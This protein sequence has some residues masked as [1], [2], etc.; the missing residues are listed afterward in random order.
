MILRQVVQV[1]IGS[2]TCSFLRYK[3]LALL[4]L[5]FSNNFLTRDVRFSLLIAHH[6][7]ILVR[8]ATISPKLV[9]ITTQKVPSLGST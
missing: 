1:S 7:Y 9:A 3:P 8:A 6:K 4:Q 5:S 2:L